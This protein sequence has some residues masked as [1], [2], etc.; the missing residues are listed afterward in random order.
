MARPRR[1]FLLR[2]TL[3]Y[4]CAVHP[5]YRARL[6]KVIQ[7]AAAEYEEAAA[8]GHAG[9]T[10]RVREIAVNNLIE[11]MLSPDV[12]IGTGK[13][14]ASN[15]ATSRQIDL[16]LY[17][18]SILPPI[19]FDSSL[20]CFPIE[21][22]LYALEVKSA[23]TAEDVRAAIGAAHELSEMPYCAGAFDD[24]GEPQ[25]HAIVR[26][27]PSI[28]AFRSDL[29]QGGKTE[30]ER[31]RELDAGADTRPVI[32]E[33]CVYGRG[34]WRFE[35]AKRE[36]AFFAPTDEHDELIDFVYTLLNTLPMTIAMRHQPR[37]GAY[38]IA[39]GRQSTP[40]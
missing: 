40:A 9:L 13:I 12:Q 19:M 27:V 11:P 34:Y 25:A 38:L 10:G 29:V 20:G 7:R 18:R 33:L 37:V 1:P 26:V 22:C 8:L 35:G 5:L 31:Y 3:G 32:R 30:I 15:G 23:L 6:V 36:W 4:P 21:A 2:S 16:I 24:A 17:C 14:V 39:N 28:F